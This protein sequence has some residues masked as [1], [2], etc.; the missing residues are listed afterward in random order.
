[1]VEVG[2]PFTMLGREPSSHV[3]LQ[4]SSSES[5]LKP[6]ISDS[7]APYTGGHPEY[8]SGTTAGPGAGNKTGGFAPGE[9]GACSR[10]M[11]K[12]PC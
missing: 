1:M 8:G 5:G 7:T 2:S 11:M 10:G 4:Q 3:F 12:H 6:T 9:T